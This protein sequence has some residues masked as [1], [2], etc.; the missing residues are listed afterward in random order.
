M[1]SFCSQWVIDSFSC[2]SWGT[3]VCNHV[4]KIAQELKGRVPKNI[5]HKILGFHLFSIF[6]F[7]CLWFNMISP[8]NAQIWIFS[9]SMLLEFLAMDPLKTKIYL[10]HIYKSK[11]GI[12]AMCTQ[13]DLEAICKRPKKRI[14]S[15]CHEFWSEEVQIKN[16]PS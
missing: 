13:L 1:G 4:A 14:S 11:L 3:L 12:W 8:S 10:T 6:Y 16:T 9:S 7:F 2:I 15:N 5:V